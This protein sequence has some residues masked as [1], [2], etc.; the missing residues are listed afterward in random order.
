MGITR[1][2]S[3]EIRT[4][5][6]SLDGA[7]DVTREVAI[8]RLAVIGGRA[9]DQLTA[10]YSERA[11]S[12][13]RRVSIL[14]VLEAASDARAVQ[15]AL[16]GLEEGAD[17]AVAAAAALRALLAA[18]AAETST[19]ALDALIAKAMDRSAERRVRLAAFDALQELPK[20]VRDR[21]NVAIGGASHDGDPGST[22]RL[23][24]R[25]AADAVWED[26]LD[27]HLPDD[28]VV[29]REAVETRAALAPLGALQKL[30]DATRARETGGPA[31][32]S[33]DWQALRGSL[34][35]ALALR[36]SRVALYDLRETLERATGVL[37]A[38]FLAALHVIGDESCLE[39]IAAAFLSADADERWRYQLAGAFAAVVR[40]KKIPGS[41]RALKRIAV[42]W[43]DAAQI[44]SKPS[45]TRARRKLPGRT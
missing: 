27:G 21:V 16:Q 35:Q 33:H 4:L 5:I 24:G 28:P 10:A 30:I 7:D 36:G 37:P 22:S 1:S 29:L 40:R 20:G 26:A 9:V 31:A 43:P 18:P 38:T 23:K 39:P 2:V 42:R 15:V 41:S 32:R 14:R 17:V 19:A 13:E 12:R 6:A 3:A 34:H 8:A 25:T 11:A 44:L 45:R